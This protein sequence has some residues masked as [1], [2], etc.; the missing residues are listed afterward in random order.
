RTGPRYAGPGAGDDWFFPRRP[1]FPGRA[2]A[3]DVHLPVAARWP[4]GPA[5][6]T[7]PAQRDN[8]PG[9]SAPSRTSS[10]SRGRSLVVTPTVVAHRGACGVL[11][12][13]TLGAYR[14]AIR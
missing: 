3:P 1:A 12:E 5:L 13:H 11:P 10:R 2:P 9:T 7:C 8:M 14:H 4:A 6:A